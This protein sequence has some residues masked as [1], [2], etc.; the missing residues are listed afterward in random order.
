MTAIGSIPGDE[1]CPLLGFDNLRKFNYPCH[2]SLETGRSLSLFMRVCHH[3]LQ[4]EG[5]K[6]AIFFHSFLSQKVRKDFAEKKHRDFSECLHPFTLLNTEWDSYNYCLTLDLR[7]F[8][9]LGLCTS[10]TR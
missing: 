7:I 3:F 10:L 6:W 5:L 4:Q 1:N 8:C 9:S 2:A